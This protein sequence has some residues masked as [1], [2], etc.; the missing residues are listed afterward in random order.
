M[1]RFETFLPTSRLTCFIAAAAFALAGAGC[2]GAVESHESTESVAQASSALG[3]RSLSLSSPSVM[4]GGSFTATVTLTG[5][6]QGSLDGVIV[7]L[8]FNEGVLAGP[9]FVRIPNGMSSGSATFY[10]NPFLPAPTS[11]TITAS[12][13]SPQPSTFLT[14]ALTV[15]P[16]PGSAMARPNVASITVSPASVTSG[17]A[18]SGTVTLTGPAPVAGAVVQ[19]ANPNDF[20]NLDAEVPAVVIVPAGATSASFT[21]WTHLS[22]GI[23]G[24][25]D[26]TIVANYFG[27]PYEG[28]A[29]T[30]R[31]ASR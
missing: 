29:L 19:L 31:A 13:A 15:V 24:F 20:F 28:A 1:A 4:G 26:E 2:G 7:Y 17:S 5:S 25:V 14:Q 8:G 11:V 22:S 18:A 21:V 23:A 6:A 9:R 30:V 3:L 10:A 12:T 16:S 27:G